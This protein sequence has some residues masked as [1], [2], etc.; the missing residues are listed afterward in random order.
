MFNF[1][2]FNLFVIFW[3]LVSFFFYFTIGDMEYKC[4]CLENTLVLLNVLHKY[5]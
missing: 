5:N 3:S 1:T 4:T 2:L